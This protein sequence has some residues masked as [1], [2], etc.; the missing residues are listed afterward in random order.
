MYDS[1]NDET[2]SG[3]PL[4]QEVELIVNL[5]NG[6]R[7][8]SEEILNYDSYSFLGDIGGYVGGLLGYSFLTLFDSFCAFIADFYVLYKQRKLQ[9]LIQNGKPSDRRRES[10]V[11]ESYF[12]TI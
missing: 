10:V 1:I 9:K 8:L 11:S 4:D 3:G 5:W 2:L 7:T 6:E 12:Q